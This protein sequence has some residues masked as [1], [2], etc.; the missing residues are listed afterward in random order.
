MISD[1]RPKNGHKLGS[2]GFPM[3]RIW[4]APYYHTSK[5]FSKPKGTQFMTIL[6]LMSDLIFLILDIF[7]YMGLYEGL[8]RYMKVY[9]HI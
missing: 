7:M 2:R 8:K 1:I 3:A 4:H 5:S 6:G 9:K